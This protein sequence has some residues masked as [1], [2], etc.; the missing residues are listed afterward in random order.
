MTLAEYRGKV[1]LLSFWASWCFPCIKLIPH[2][3][4]LAARLKD[5]P[6]VIVGINS[7]A[8]PATALEVVAKH[9]IQWR[10]FR[11]R[12]AG[13]RPISGAWDILGYPTLYL[14]DHAGVIRKRW[15]GS[16]PPADLDREVDRLVE[17]ASPN[18]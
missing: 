11:D 15:I 8:D 17:A 6:F 18:R 14:I 2:E 13:E 1:V 12:A 5:R 4:A 16:P 7:D 9:Q 10:S 3:Q